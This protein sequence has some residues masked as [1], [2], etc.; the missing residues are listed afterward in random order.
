M[1]N[2]LCFMQAKLFFLLVY[3]KM[4]FVHAKL[5]V[6]ISLYNDLSHLF[7]FIIGHLDKHQYGLER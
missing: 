3:A 5:L 2:Y 1:P 7:M 6:H 4:C